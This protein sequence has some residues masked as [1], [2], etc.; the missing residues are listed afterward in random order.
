MQAPLVNHLD[1]AVDEI[2]DLL[3]EEDR[4]EDD[5]TFHPTPDASKKAVQMLAEANVQ[6]RGH[7]PEAAIFPTG[8][9]GLR[10]Q[11]AA[12]RREVRLLIPADE[13]ARTLLYHEQ[14]DDYKL[15]VIQSGADLAFWL[16]WLIPQA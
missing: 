13:N 5:V 15:E 1:S 14:G 4:T 2:F 3:F 12:G 16:K 10:L 6:L 8:E 11:W 7:L 9:Q